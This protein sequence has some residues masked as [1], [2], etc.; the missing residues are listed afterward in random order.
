MD[1]SL[2]ANFLSQVQPAPEAV[3]GPGA[4]LHGL[5]AD[6]IEH[7]FDSL[8]TRLAPDVEME[9][10]GFGPFDGRWSGREDVRNAVRR[11]MELVDE[12]RP[13]MRRMIQHGDDIVVELAESG[14]FRNG[15][16]YEARGVQWFT[17]RN[18]EVARIYQVGRLEQA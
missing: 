4:R 14:K 18:G 6:T 8:A 10:A 12:Q 17:F 13:E 1:K 3:E 5:Y 7:N 11:N 15:Q 2:T 16:A 9:I